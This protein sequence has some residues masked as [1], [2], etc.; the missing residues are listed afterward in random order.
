MAS[1]H[2][3]E[4]TELLQFIPS[5]LLYLKKT[6]KITHKNINLKTDYLINIIHRSLTNYYNN[7]KET[8][9]KEIK[10]QLSS[11]ILKKKYGVYYNYYI[12]YLRSIDFL[13]MTTDYY[14]GGNTGK[15]RTYKLHYKYLTDI[16]RIKI[17][18]RVLLKKYNHENLIAAFTTYVKSP[19]PIPIRKKLVNDLYYIELDYNESVKYLNKL[20]KDGL[21]PYKY[22]KNLMALEDINDRQ[23]YFK[24]DEYGRFHTNFTTLK[25]DIRKNFLKIDG[26]DLV[27]ID[28]SNSQPL[29][30]AHLMKKTL[31]IKELINPEFSKY[32][33]LVEKGL[34]YEEIMDKSGINCREDVK[35]IMYRVLFGR[36]GEVATENKIFSSIFPEVFSFIKKY[37]K[38]RN[39]HKSLSH[40]LQQLESEFIFN[41]VISYIMN[42]HPE[43]K[44]FTVHDSINVPLKYKEIV[45]DI[46][47][48]YQRKILI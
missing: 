26:E 39:N 25:K 13:I 46:F 2:L 9:D 17:Y 27:E 7:K 36:N 32:F 11:I 21:N 14:N 16:T 34:L 3:K 45:K 47:N 41:N 8:I 24:F 43:I 22:N 19:I 30:L 18:D 37:K 4:K 40:K 48:Y 28:I 29:F 35:I 33:D 15:A 38:D 23:L 10:F 42:T 6:K 5:Q 44:L 20:K 31:T 12:D 1:Y